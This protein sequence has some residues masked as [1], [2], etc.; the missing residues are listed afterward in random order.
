M[1]NSCGSCKHGHDR[2]PG[3]AKAS[4]GTVWCAQRSMQMGNIRQMPCFSGS[5]GKAI[6]RCTACKRAKMNT[7][8][9]EIP[10]LGNVWCDKRRLEV[11]KQSSMECFE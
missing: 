5:A 10:R 2:K 6:H 7:P 4:P 11:N 3:G 9:G 8:T 1:N